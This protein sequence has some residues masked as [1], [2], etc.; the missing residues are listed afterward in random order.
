MVDWPRN[1]NGKKKEDRG[2]LPALHPIIVFIADCNHQ[3]RTYV[4]AYF[5]LAGMPQQKSKW[6]PADAKS[7]GK[8]SSML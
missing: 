3:V 8:S 7:L 6:R 2:E 1:K 4:K 5:L